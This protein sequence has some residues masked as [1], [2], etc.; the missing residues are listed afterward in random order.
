MADLDLEGNPKKETHVET[1]AV[2]A[3][4]QEA[5]NMIQLNPSVNGNELVIMVKMLEALNRNVAFLANTIYEH[6][7]PGKKV[8]KNG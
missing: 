7:N 6:L 3:P 5:K 1:K 4:P 8:E 2:D